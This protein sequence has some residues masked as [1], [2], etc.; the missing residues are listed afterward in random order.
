MITCQNQVNNNWHFLFIIRNELWTEVINMLLFC[1]IRQYV[2]RDNAKEK[3]TYI[4]AP[5][6]DDHTH[7]EKIIA[8][9]SG[10]TTLKKL[11]IVISLL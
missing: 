9:T 5:K 7:R 4:L 2:V 11:F 8:G 10:G 1:D 6:R 3:P